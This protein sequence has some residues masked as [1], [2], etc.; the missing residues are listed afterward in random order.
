M[1]ALRV[2]AVLLLA[3]NPPVVFDAPTL[4]KTVAPSV[5]VVRS[6]DSN[7][8]E[9]ALGSGVVIGH[10]LVA[11]NFHVVESAARIA[12]SQQGRV[13]V[14]SAVELDRDH[15]VAIVAAEQLGL[16]RVQLG[17]LDELEI[18]SR[19]FVIG[20]PR[21]LE[22]TLSEGIVSGLR[23]EG[24]NRLIQITAP[25]SA[26]SS[27]G[28]V[29]NDRGRLVGLSTLIVKESQ[30]LNFALPVE[31]VKNALARSRRSRTSSEWNNPFGATTARPS[32]DGEGLASPARIS[33]VETNEPAAPQTRRETKPVLWAQQGGW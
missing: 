21:G 33:S 12:V 7:G 14:A 13:W 16:P 18:G 4:F 26:G 10:D 11:T 3:A 32:R 28:G 30:N 22:A 23:G 31:W 25:I 9:L 2:T 5:V 20:S 6:F 29:F 27:G 24:T 17:S 19:V 15:D 8:Q 1:V